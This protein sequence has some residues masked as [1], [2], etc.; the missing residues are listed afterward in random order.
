PVAGVVFWQWGVAAL[1]VLY[2]LENL[3][4][5][6]VTVPRILVSSVSRGKLSG[7][8]G[9]I[10]NSGFFTF[11]YGMFCLCHG[12]ILMAFLTGDNSYSQGADLGA[13]VGRIFTGAF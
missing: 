11:H 1:V 5:G 7:I 10:L 13:M 6:S 4:I 9:G 2:W 3:V 8:F 12:A